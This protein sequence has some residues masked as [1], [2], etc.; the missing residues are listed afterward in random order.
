MRSVVIVIVPPLPQLVI[1]EVNVVANATLVEELVELLVIDTVRAF[2]L[3]VQV[4]RSRA[5]VDDPGS[6]GASGTVTGIP[7]RCRLHNMDA[8]PQPPEHIVDEP[9]RRALVAAVVDL[10]HTDPRAVVD[11]G[12]LI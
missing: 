4:R 11:R 9:D 1:E 10:E 2:D 6:R 8:K 7:R 3:A 5:D 12:E